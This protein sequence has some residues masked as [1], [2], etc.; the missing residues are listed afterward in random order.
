MLQQRVEHERARAPHRVE[1]GDERPQHRRHQIGLGQELR[2]AMVERQQVVHE[3]GL[4]GPTVRVVDRPHGLVELLDPLTGAPEARGSHQHGRPLA[5]DARREER[6]HEDDHVVQVVAGR[7]A[8]SDG[9]ELLRD[10]ALQ[11]VQ[12][13]D[14]LVE[15]PLGN[16]ASRDGNHVVQVLVD[17]RAR[18]ARLLRLAHP[19]VL[20]PVHAHHRAR[21]AQLLVEIHPELARAE[22]PAALTRDEQVGLRS[23]KHGEPAVERA[24]AEDG[25]ELQVLPVKNAPTS[26]AMANASPTRGKLGALGGACDGV[27]IIRFARAPAA[28]D[29]IL[30]SYTVSRPSRGHH[31]Q[32]SSV[33]TDRV[34]QCHNPAEQEAY[35]SGL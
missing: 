32:T 25:T 28:A 30:Q 34:A 8:G 20:G 22:V 33:K 26:P 35:R 9:A 11:R 23:R 17:E 2:V 10:D 1:P 24:D 27:A 18:V 29:S 12:A 16:L 19:G 13:G 4:A 6:A 21:R 5:R 14:G 15:G 31:R 3:V 7:H